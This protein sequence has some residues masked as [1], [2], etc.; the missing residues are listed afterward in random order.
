M[1][2]ACLTVLKTKAMKKLILVIIPIILLSYSTCY[3]QF[4]YSV[5]CN[6][7]ASTFVEKDNEPS[8]VAVNGY[9][10]APSFSL[11]FTA[12][13]PILI[14]DLSVGIGLGYSY[15]SSKNEVVSESWTDKLGYVSSPIFLKYDINEYLLSSIGVENS[16]KLSSSN[17]HGL[18]VLSY[19]LAFKA[20]IGVR[21][22]E[23]YTIGLE[24]YNDVI[25]SFS[26]L[27]TENS[28]YDIN[29]YKRQ[30]SL[31]IGYDF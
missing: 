9:K 24:F 7:G 10:F 23:H 12:S 20:M 30:F 27:E 29:Y 26:L 25:P 1:Y 21:V 17:M 11:G 14:D 3:A 31:K 13:H 22:K 6:L 2:S 19:S 28:S 5:Y 8:V 18:N 15:F 16:F 4:D